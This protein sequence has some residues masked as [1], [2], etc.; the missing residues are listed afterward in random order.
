LAAA[1][2]IALMCRSLAANNFYD[3]WNPSAGLFP[4][5]LLIFVCWSLA[6]GDYWLLPLAV[7]VASFLAQVEDAFL[8]P[9]IAA[10]AVGLGGLAIARV[11]QRRRRPAV[12]AP[13]WVGLG[14]REEHDLRRRGSM[15]PWALAA[16]VVLLLCLTPPAIDQVAPRGHFGLVVKAA[17]QR[18]TALGSRVGVHAVVRMVGITPWWLTH[19]RW[20]ANP[21]EPFVR[22]Y[23]VRR[24]AS[25]LANAST[26][27]ILGWLLLAAGL[28]IR[29][30]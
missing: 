5:L 15:W 11:E 29:R 10:M 16:L 14:R 21:S 26:V 13:G 23:D 1:V 7:F 24:P 27:V 8:P 30:R 6:C 17:T 9:T 20:L 22:K 3:I 4:L 2:G 19:P 12:A 28:A 25:T 18:K